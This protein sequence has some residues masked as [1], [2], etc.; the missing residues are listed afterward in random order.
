[1][2]A[3]MREKVINPIIPYTISEKM[4]VVEIVIL[5]VAVST[6]CSGN[7]FM[8]HPTKVPL[9]ALQWYPVIRLPR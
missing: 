2:K 5:V 1:M 6:L 8:H 9:G 7:M 3:K 4:S